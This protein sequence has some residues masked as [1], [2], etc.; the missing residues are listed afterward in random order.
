MFKLM[1]L[2]LQPQPE[3]INTIAIFHVIWYAWERG[4]VRDRKGDKNEEDSHR[5]PQTY[6]RIYT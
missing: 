3:K 1:E 5:F 6:L 2:L 4:K